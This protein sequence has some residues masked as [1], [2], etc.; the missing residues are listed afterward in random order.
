MKFYNREE[1]LNELNY[2]YKNRPSMVVITGRR[3]IGKTELIKKIKNHIYFFV[4]SEKSEKLLIQE[5]FTILKQNFEIDDLIKINSWD[6]LFSLIFKLSEKNEIVICFDEFQR[7]LKINPSIIYQLQKYWDL[8]KNKSKLFLVFT[9]SSIGMIKKIFIENQAPLFKRAQN[10]LY[11]KPFKFD[12]I[13]EILIDLGV[14]K[15]E[16][17][18][19]IYSIFGGVI[20]YY[21]LMDFYKIKS[22]DDILKK[23]ILRKYAPLANEIKDNMVEEFGKEHKTYYSILLSL[24]LGKNTKKEIEDLVD[25][26]GTSLS[27][28]LYD[29][30][31]ILEV[32]EYNIPFNE[33]KNSKK[34]RYI[35]NDNFFKFWFKFIFRNLNYY[36]KGDFD[37]LYKY[38]NQNIN[39]FIGYGFEDF[40]KY[41][42]NE[43]KIKLPFKKNNLGSWWSRKGDEIDIVASNDKEILFCECKYKDNVDAEKIYNELKEKSKLVN[44]ENKIEYYVIFA[45]SFKKKINI[46]NLKLYDLK[47]IEKSFTNSICKINNN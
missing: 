29:L 20:N 14:N 9:G 33:N 21:S 24:S 10:I 38:I 41:L 6:D 11:L 27:P 39:S 1:E 31:D 17:R 25:V 28:Y 8:K 23:L 3:R 4:D 44:K 16:E 2:F 5:Y 26:K 47:D 46:N 40:C 12:I 43:E 34:G 35:L 32:V 37:Y 7:F 30:I 18:I 15:L 19:K 22:F 36:E 45:K 13:N 42:I